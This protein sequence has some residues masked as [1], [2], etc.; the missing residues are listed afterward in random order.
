MRLTKNKI[1]D[2]VIKII[3]TKGLPLIE[4][5]KDKENISEFELAKKLNLDIKIVRKMLYLL[6]N[7][8]L[9]S[10]TRQKDKQK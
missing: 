3:G 8:S 9:V 6:Y 4:L 5:L 2:V 10:F 7:H 1:N